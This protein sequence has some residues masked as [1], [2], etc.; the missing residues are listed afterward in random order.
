MRQVLDASALLIY[1][2]KQR[3]YEKVAK[4]LAH[5]YDSQEPLFI[6]AVTW[7]EVVYILIRTDG[8]DR[9][10]KTVDDLLTFPIDIVPVDRETAER[11][12]RY[13]AERKLGYAD[14]FAAALAHF[15]SGEL[16]TSDRGF[17]AVARDIRISWI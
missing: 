11:A 5:A 9:A 13:K 2:R 12:A 10:K 17:E 3:G 7:G 4:S 15:S 14:S 1:L 16:L 6:S 8:A